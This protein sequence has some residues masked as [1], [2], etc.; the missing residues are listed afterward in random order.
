[1]NTTTIADILIDN[2]KFVEEVNRRAQANIEAA[3]KRKQA[4]RTV[5]CKYY[6]NEFVAI[7]ADEDEQY[8]QCLAE[9]KALNVE[10]TYPLPYPFNI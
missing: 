10:E 1:M 6:K 8:K 2:E 4:I 5:I 3:N 9:V 7:Q